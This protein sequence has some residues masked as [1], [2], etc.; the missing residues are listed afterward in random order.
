[1]NSVSLWLAVACIA[2]AACAVSMLIL[3]RCRNTL[4]AP[5]PGRVRLPLLTRAAMPLALL[6]EPCVECLLPPGRVA[7]TSRKLEALGLGASVSVPRWEALRAAQALAC[8][9]LAALA[10]GGT[11]WIC[12]L[13]AAGGYLFGGIWLRRQHE[14]LQRSVVRDLPAWLDL[15]T[16]CVEAGATLT[17]GLRLIVAQAPESPLREFFDHVLREVRGGRARA[18]AFS[19]VASM[20]AI[21]SLDTLASALSHAESSGM[22]LGRVL[23]SQAEQR[24]A[25]RF[26]RA[27][28][29]AM[30]APV[31]MLGPLILCIFPCTFIVIGVPIAVRLKEALGA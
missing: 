6:L 27:E 30:Q 9:M 22:S 3:R 29:L 15:M 17:S 12:M 18:Q 20:Y 25:E 10:S 26:A 5:V 28:K 14:S 2:L 24:T 13:L 8:G 19:H 23:R 7:R 1:M 31:K 4:A 11:L 16:V 21:E